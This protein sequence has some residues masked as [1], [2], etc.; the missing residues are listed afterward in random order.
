M[1]I[2]EEDDTEEEGLVCFDSLI[3]VLRVLVTLVK[4]NFFYALSYFLNAAGVLV[5][6]SSGSSDTCF[7]NF[8]VFVS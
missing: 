2:M 6:I 7:E 1:S 3:E 4:L 5:V 8:L